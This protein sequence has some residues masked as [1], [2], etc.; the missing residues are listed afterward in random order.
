MTVLFVWLAV[1]GFC[2]AFTPL[3]IAHGKSLFP[4]HLVG[5]GI[6]VFNTGTMAGGFVSQIVSGGV[7]ELFPTQNGAYPL[8]AYQIVFLLQ[9][10][11]VA[12]ALTF[13]GK[14]KDPLPL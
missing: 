11:F 6:T 10:A 3:V 2:A 9:A 8:V 4:P 1:F 13:Y 12:T 5:R 7:I 14:V